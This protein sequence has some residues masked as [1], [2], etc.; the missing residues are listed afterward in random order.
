MEI[1]LSL[2]FISYLAGGLLYLLLLA[3]YFVGSQPGKTSKP[4]MFL[5]CATLV[6]SAL[7]TL[8]QVGAS[9]A[10]EIVVIAE[11]MRYFTWF[12]ILHTAAGYF[13]KGKS[14]FSLTNPLTPANVSIVFVLALLSLAVNDLLVDRLLL[15][16]PV[17]ILLGWLLAFSLLGLLLVEQVFRNTPAVNRGS[18][19]L[20]CI[21]AG[22]IFAYDFFVFSNAVL[23]RNIDYEFWS[24]RGIVNIVAAPTLVLAAVRN[25]QMAPGMH[26]SRKFVFHS[27]TLVC[28]GVYFVVMAFIGYY[29]KHSSGEWGKLI[30]T[31]FFFAAL[32]LLAVVFSS[33]RLKA[34]I[35]RYLSHSFRNKYDYR[36]EWNRF[37]RTLLAPN[38]EVSIH[39]RAIQAIGQIVDSKGGSLWIRDNGLF[40]YQGSWQ[41]GFETGVP[42]QENSPLIEYLLTRHEPF[43]GS[44]LQDLIGDETDKSDGIAGIVNSWLI[45]PL[46][47]N[48]ELFGFVC[49]REPVVGNDLDIEDRDLL[50]TVAHHVALALFLRETDNR[51]QRAQRF[52]DLNQMT[53]FLV[54]DLKTV[55]SQLSLLVENADR[56]RHNPEFVDDMIETVNHTTQKMQRLLQQLRDPDGQAL[57]SRVPIVP[58]LKEITASCGNSSVDVSFNSEIADNIEIDADRAQ[59]ESAIRHLVQ[60]GVESVLKDGR[61]DIEARP[62]NA[63]SVEISI[64]DNGE[65]MT[66]EF[67]S[68]K[69]FKPFESTKGVSGMGVGVFQSREYIR[70]I[71]GNIDVVSQPGIGTEFRIRLPLGND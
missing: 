39:Q 28:A 37:S 6:W 59:L 13:Q 69:L 52:K 30:Q 14:G 27:T 17:I 45:L 15:D 63:G 54:H 19:T 22:A 38:A 49:L 16:P 36:D 21:S 5:L 7:L 53:A 66:K 65:G 68:E 35:K 62:S 43:S 34:R 9:I 26:I 2:G 29:V 57:R 46:W 1:N 12:Y 50:H 64:K 58:L 10:F 3:I 71:D 41:N 67:I 51:L 60:N 8:S 32:L 70:S 31:A 18:I 56:H 11:M 33:P 44:R 42:L 20:M 47:I 40:H 25:P 61:V 48:D 55:F 4:F 24:A 23:V